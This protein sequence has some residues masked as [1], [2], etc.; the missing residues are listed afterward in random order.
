MS[1][2]PA[3]Y[4]AFQDEIVKLGAIPG[5]AAVVSK[6]RGVG[7]K[8]KSWASKGWH[9][10]MGEGRIIVPE[11]SRTSSI[12]SWG[13]TG[14]GKYTQYLP[15]GGK[16]VFVGMTAPAIPGALK[17]EDPYGAAR[18]RTERA[19]D[20]GSNVMGGLIGGGAAISLP[21]KGW[22]G[23]RALVGGA[24]GAMLAARLA[25]MPWRR[26]RKAQQEAA[27]AA[28]YA[29]QQQAPQEE[30]PQSQARSMGLQGLRQV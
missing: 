25:T 29:P 30:D 3:T 17:K 12:P 5:Q 18:S 13:W 22:K 24:S 8:L 1:L 23:T 10:P 2:D 27:A 4:Q 26:K 14:K 6:L 16:S 28:G 7:S 19:V 21:M 15:I 11:V 9:D 20:L